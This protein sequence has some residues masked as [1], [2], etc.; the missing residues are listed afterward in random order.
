MPALHSFSPRWLPNVS[1]S[2]SR[3]RRVVN[4]L[5]SMG[6]IG[7][8]GGWVNLPRRNR[9]QTRVP[10]PPQARLVLLRRGRRPVHPPDTQACA[11]VSALRG[12]LFTR[13]SPQT[14]PRGTAPPGFISQLQARLPWPHLPWDQQGNEPVSAVGLTFL[15]SQKV[16]LHFMGSRIW[17]SKLANC[18][19]RRK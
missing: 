18:D 2:L 7:T 17:E 4:S 5:L 19:V 10:P 1:S 6:K 9:L 11:P 12:G 13:P 8:P 3:H 15:C 14:E 16:E